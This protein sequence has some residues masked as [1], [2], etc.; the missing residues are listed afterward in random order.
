MSH[1][2]SVRELRRSGRLEMSRAGGGERASAG[3]YASTAIDRN[4]F[5]PDIAAAVK[6]AQLGDRDAFCF[7][8]LRYRNN[9]YGYILSI[10]R[11]PHEAEDATQHVFLKLM[12]VIGS[13]RPQQVPFS[14]WIIRVARNVAVDYQ[15]QHRAIPVEEVLESSKP[16]EELGLDRRRGLEHA[17]QTLPSEQRDVV[18]LRH[19]VGLTPGEIASRLGR[20]EASIHGL[21]HRGRQAIKRQLA[22]LECAPTTQTMTRAVA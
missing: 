10:L 1:S 4:D 16:S 14:A 11:D 15:R 7:L 2:S 6:R 19:L 17:L 8:Y 20:S 3:F 22:E 18:V 5:D 9:V 21:H 12:S 13:Y